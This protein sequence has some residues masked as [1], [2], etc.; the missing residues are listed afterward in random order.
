M[1]N[2]KRIMMP[3][4]VRQQLE[5]LTAENTELRQQVSE[6]ADAL[7]ELAEMCVIEEE[8]TDNG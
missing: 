5:N 2:F 6:Q 7:I 4:Y 1:F 3:L 8:E